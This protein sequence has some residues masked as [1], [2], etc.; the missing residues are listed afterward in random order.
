MAYFILTGR[1]RYICLKILAYI[2]EIAFGSLFFAPVSVRRSSVSDCS[3]LIKTHAP[4]YHK[5][6]SVC[7]VY[8]FETVL[9]AMGFFLIL[10]L[11]YFGWLCSKLCERFSPSMQPVLFSLSSSKD[12]PVPAGVLTANDKL[13][14][15]QAM[16]F[17]DCNASCFGAGKRSNC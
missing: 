7:G 6:Q 5:A 3:L 17:P 4:L 15:W 12:C 14:S 9:L 10:T 13:W 2:G 11:P 1:F 16:W 8:W